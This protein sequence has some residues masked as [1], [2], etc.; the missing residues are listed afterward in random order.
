MNTLRK[1]KCFT[2][3]QTV[4]LFGCST[5]T[6]RLKLRQWKAYTSYNQNGRYYT[7]PGVPR[8]DDN[9]LWR[10]RGIYFSKCGTLKNTVVHLSGVSPAGLTG[11]Q[12]G[13]FVGISPSS[14]LHHFRSTAGIRREKHQG[15]YVYF[16]QDEDRY[17]QQAVRRLEEIA[18]GES[19]SDADAIVLLV[20]LIKHHDITVDHL[21]SLPEM[22]EKGLQASAI[23]NYLQRHGLGKKTLRSKH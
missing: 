9:G 21:T 18:L 19:I 7:L 20:A 6:V 10:H 16:A 8:F 11:E 14:F 15:V 2:L 12:L 22:K 13:E 23:D 3:D 5:P 1:K 4:A 17:K